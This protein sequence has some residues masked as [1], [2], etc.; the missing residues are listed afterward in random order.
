MPTV[1]CCVCGKEF[2]RSQKRINEAAKLNYRSVCSKQ[3]QNT[4]NTDG[5]NNR[6]A[7][8][9]II[10]CSFCGKSLKKKQSEITKSKSGLVFC[11][12]L[13]RAKSPKIRNGNHRSN[14]ELWIE[15]QLNKEYPTLEIIFNDKEAINAELDIYIP[16]L[17]LAFELNGPFHYEPIFGK[18]ALSKVQNND[19]RK[20]QACLEQGIELCIIDT[21]HQ[22][23]FT[24]ASSLRYL[25]VIKESDFTTTS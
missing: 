11:S 3:C 9:V 6:K 13:C 10:P 22:K 16:K 4:L 14:L 25:T 19:A 21:T 2:T 15:T 20:F 24:E 18:D 17:N 23:R 5:S 12:Y 8:S 1:I 7:S